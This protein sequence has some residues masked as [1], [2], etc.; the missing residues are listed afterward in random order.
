[1]P[2]MAAEAKIVGSEL[3]AVLPRDGRP[4]YTKGSLLQLN[5]CLFSLI[6]YSSANGYDGSMMNGLQA[7][8]Q[9][10]D[11]M[12]H[13]TGAWL[14]FINAIQ[15]VGAFVGYPVVAWFVNRYGRKKSIAIGYFWLLL[16]VGLQTG[17][18]NQ[19]MFIMGRFFLGQ[20]TAWFAGAAPL[21]ITETAYPTHRGVATA[22]YNTGWYVGECA[23]PLCYRR[24]GTNNP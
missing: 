5:F 18:T 3:L 10:Q 8:T 22:L 7:L 9:W 1:M 21:L 13:P 15:S 19:T 11:F 12:Q 17:A 24:I 20:V 2:A 6:L 16:G 23:A 4:W 14:G